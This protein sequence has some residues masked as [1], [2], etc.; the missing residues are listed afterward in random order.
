V[1]S[2]D[3]ITPIDA[4]TYSFGSTELVFTAVDGDR[5][6]ARYSGTLSIEGGVAAINGG[7]QIFGGTGRFA[8]ATG[9]GAL[10]GVENIATV[11]ATGQVQLIGTISY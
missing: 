11:P 7:F 5:I 2:T 10:Q 6:F 3:C 1:T 8:Q 4:S 9:A